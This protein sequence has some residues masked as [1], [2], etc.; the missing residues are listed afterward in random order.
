MDRAV[1]ANVL[2]APPI[3]IISTASAFPSLRRPTRI[4]LLV[5]ASDNEG[6]AVAAEEVASSPPSAPFSTDLLRSSALDSPSDSLISYAN[7]QRALRGEALSTPDHYGMLGLAP[8]APYEEVEIAFRKRCEAVLQQQGLSEDEI[9]N[10]LRAL[11]VAY[12]VLSSEE[13]RRL[14]DWSLFHSKSPGGIYRWPYESDITQSACA[15]GP[16]KEPK[17]EEG[18]RKVGYFFLGWFVLSVFL[19]LSLR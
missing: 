18:I 11:K 8:S 2:S 16:P 9:R 13:E 14:Y 7:I 12:D 3:I 4:K 19:N 6:A 10:R 15:P 5:T 1:F 17:D